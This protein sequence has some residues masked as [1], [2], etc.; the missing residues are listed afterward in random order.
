MDESASEDEDFIDDSE[1]QDTNALEDI[2]RYRYDLAFM[3]DSNRILQHTTHDTFAVWIRKDN[4]E[5]FEFLGIHQKTV[6]LRCVNH[7]PPHQ[8]LR[9]TFDSFFSTRQSDLN[10]MFPEG[11]EMTFDVVAPFELNPTV[12][13]KH[14]PESVP[15]KEI[16]YTVIVCSALQ[17]DAPISQKLF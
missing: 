8:M 1:E 17:S 9:A 13:I 7:A 4:G 14:Y 11:R 15:E 3:Y 5:T 10:D 16:E 12:I 6:R 2:T